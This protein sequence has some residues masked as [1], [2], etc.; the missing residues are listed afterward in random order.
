MYACYVAIVTSYGAK[1]DGLKKLSKGSNSKTEKGR[2][3]VGD[4]A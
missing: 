3:F 1:K 2:A 4:I